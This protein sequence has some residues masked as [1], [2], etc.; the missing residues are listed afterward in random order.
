MQRKANISSS[1]QLLYDQMLAGGIVVPTP[2]NVLKY[3]A[4]LIAESEL[5]IRNLVDDFDG[6]IEEIEIAGIPC[7]QI[8]PANWSHE[9]GACIQYAYGG[10]YVSGSNWEDQV[11]TIPMAQLSNARVVMVD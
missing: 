9:T 1:A 10:G 4:D 5:T 11:I 8:T 3:R 7:K 6:V 2:D